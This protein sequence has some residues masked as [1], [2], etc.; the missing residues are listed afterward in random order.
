MNKYTLI[1]NFLKSPIFFVV[2]NFIFL[3]LILN[4]VN[5]AIRKKIKLGWREKAQQP[6]ALAALS[7]NLGAFPST[8]MVVYN[9]L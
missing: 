8:H 7:E 2:Y 9:A 3:I 5:F 1:I 6:K 4:M